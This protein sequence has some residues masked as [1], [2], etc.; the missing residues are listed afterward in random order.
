VLAAFA[1]QQTKGGVQFD[2]GD[3]ARML[4]ATLLVMMIQPR[5]A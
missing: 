1:L 3:V 2:S 4:T 5:L